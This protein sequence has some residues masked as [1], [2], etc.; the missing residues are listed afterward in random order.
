[1]LVAITVVALAER[2]LQAFPRFRVKDWPP[3]GRVLG[4]VV[5]A[6]AGIPLFMEQIADRQGI[7]DLACGGAVAL[8]V[9]PEGLP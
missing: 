3:Y 2:Q 4:T 9:G 8:R 6:D 1:M 7:E 5:L